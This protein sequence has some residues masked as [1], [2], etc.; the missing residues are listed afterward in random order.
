MQYEEENT[1]WETFDFT[2]KCQSVML[3]PHFQIM[4]NSK[5]FER[6]GEKA[7]FQPEVNIVALNRPLPSRI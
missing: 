7:I 4:L 6:G 2:L 3:H 5:D 1:E